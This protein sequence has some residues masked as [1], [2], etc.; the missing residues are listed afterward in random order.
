MIISHRHKFI[1][2]KTNKTASTSIEIALSEFCDH[3]D[4]ITPIAAKDEETRSELGYQSS[5]NFFTPNKF[6]Y[7]NIQKDRNKEKKLKKHEGFYN[8]IS[9]EYI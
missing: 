7:E 1:F 5:Q 8:H 9:A 3:Q 2:I 4:I 6:V